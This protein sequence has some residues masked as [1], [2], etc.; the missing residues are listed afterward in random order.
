MLAGAGQ[1]AGQGCGVR[2][3]LS[4]DKAGHEGFR[5]ESYGIAFSNSGYLPFL[6]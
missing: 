2:C 3:R 1:G 6:F 4:A 5:I